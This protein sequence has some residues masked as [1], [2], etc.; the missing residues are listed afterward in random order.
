MRPSGDQI[1][2]ATGSSS[3]VTRSGHL[4]SLESV[5]DVASFVNAG[6]IWTSKG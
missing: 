5:S 1:T 3:A 4:P 6:V 2:V